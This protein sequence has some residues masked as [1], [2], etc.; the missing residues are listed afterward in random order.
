MLDEA[1][2][3]LHYN[4]LPHTVAGSLPKTGISP[5]ILGSFQ[6]AN[7]TG[8]TI[9]LS[10]CLH[11][12]LTTAIS[13]SS[14]AVKLCELYSYI[15]EYKPGRK[16]LLCNTSPIPQIFN[17]YIVYDFSTTM[18]FKLFCLKS[19][20]HTF[21]YCKN[22]SIRWTSKWRWQLLCWSSFPKTATERI[23][24]GHPFV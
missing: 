3:P 9:Q 20:N 8:G 13:A 12:H 21:L 6:S 19:Q 16:H 11:I 2:A 10:F 7:I 4:P 17:Y 5:E 23:E 15:Q 18:I 14:L 22:T 1:D 24:D